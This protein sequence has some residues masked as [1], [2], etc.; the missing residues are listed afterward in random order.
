MKPEIE[1][2]LAMGKYEGDLS[3]F[4]AESITQ[5][6]AATHCS[7]SKAQE[8]LKQL[9]DG[10]EITFKMGLGREMSETEKFPKNGWYWLVPSPSTPK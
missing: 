6:R 10:G 9:R 7:E 5:I 4:L 1:V 3:P 8:I 2:L